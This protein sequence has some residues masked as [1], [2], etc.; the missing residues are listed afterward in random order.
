MSVVRLFIA[1]AAL[2]ACLAG[3]ALAQKKD[4]T[5]LQVEEAE[6][7][8]AAEKVDRQYKAV[9][10]R[11]RKDAETRADPWANMRGA[12]DAKSKR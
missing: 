7:K 5:P 8:S 11:T 1:T 9:I 6:K 12:D 3:P 2:A 4:L 10:E